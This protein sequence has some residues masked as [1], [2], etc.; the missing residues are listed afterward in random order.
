MVNH[1]EHNDDASFAASIHPTE[2]L[3]VDF[4]YAH[5]N[6]FSSTNICYIF[7]ATA[8]AT[9]PSTAYNMGTCTVANSPAGYGGASGLYLGTGNYSAPSNFVSG[10]INYAPTKDLHFNGG[11]RFN[12]TSGTA[13]M[14]DP[15]M[16]PGALQSHY[17]TPFADVEYKIASDWAW[18]GNWTRD[19][20]SEQGPWSGT[21][22]PRNTQGDILTLGVRYA[23]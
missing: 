6:V 12:E 19:S 13:E 5:D 21:L 3:S 8:N 16:V 18:H 9:L 17:N 22:P 7:T 4:N 2:Q 10:T 14:L 15:L 20:Y 11:V 1:K 23:F